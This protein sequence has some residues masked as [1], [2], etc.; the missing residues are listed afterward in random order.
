[1]RLFLTHLPREVTNTVHK[2]GEHFEPPFFIVLYL[3]RAKPLKKLRTKMKTLHA[4]LRETFCNGKAAAVATARSWESTLPLE[5]S[6]LSC[7]PAPDETTPM[8]EVS[9][10]P[11][12]GKEYCQ[13]SQKSSYHYF[14]LQGLA[15]FACVLFL[16]LGEISVTLIKRVAAFLCRKS[17]VGN[18]PW[19]KKSLTQHRVRQIMK[20]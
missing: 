18:Y 5:I 4:V 7:P 13:R 1:M 6:L 19:S 12:C 20:G 16:S 2:P 15:R 9:A 17:L 8:P 14:L 3:Y 11:H 10:Q